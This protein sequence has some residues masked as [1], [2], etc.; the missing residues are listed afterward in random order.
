[1]DE[2]PF[3]MGAPE[4]GNMNWLQYDSVLSGSQGDFIFVYETWT[5]GLQGESE[6]KISLRQ[7]NPIAGS[8]QAG[9]FQ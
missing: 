6:K 4:T 1:M 8:N 7:P 3:N 5:G 9:R 2:S